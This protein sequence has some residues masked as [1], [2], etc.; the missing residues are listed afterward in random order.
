MDSRIEKR[1][2]ERVMILPFFIFLIPFLFSNYFFSLLFLD[3][4]LLFYFIVPKLMWSCPFPAL[5]FLSSSFLLPLSLHSTPLP[6]SQLY[7]AFHFCS[8][9]YTSHFFTLS[10]FSSSSLPLL[11]PLSTHSFQS[12]FFSIS[13]FVLTPFL[14]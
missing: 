13:Y 9:F 8:I 6:L 7:Q 12:S 10:P 4:W 11:T 2:G 3:F 5:L 14:Q 1:R